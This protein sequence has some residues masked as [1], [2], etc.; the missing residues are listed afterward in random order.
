MCGRYT[1]RYT[2][3]QI[4]ELYRLTEPAVA[5]NDFVPRYNIAPTQKAPV[6][7]ERDGRRELVMLR[8]GLIPY[9]A[10]DSNIGGAEGRRG[11][12][13][14]GPRVDGFVRYWSARGSAA[15]HTSGTR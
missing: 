5:P 4:V 1:H 10:I 3:S 9:W 15:P 12:D 7:R 14:F 6:V 2:W 13:C 11:G 8:W